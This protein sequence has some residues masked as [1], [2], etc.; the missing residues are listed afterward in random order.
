METFARVADIMTSNPH[1]V[2]LGENMANAEKLMNQWRVHH[3]PVLHEGHLRGIV[4]ERD[5]ALIRSLELDPR[6]VGVAEAL[7]PEPYTVSA[8]AP[9]GRVVRAMAAHRYECAVVVEG[10]E[11]RGIVTATDAMR[12]LA[13][14]IERHQPDHNALRPGQVRELILLEHQHLRQLL[15]RTVSAARTVIEGG[16]SEADVDAMRA[17]ARSA[18]TALVSHT[19]LED[20]ILAPVLE[21]IDAWGHVRAKSLRQEHVAQ[22]LSLQRALQ[23]VSEEAPASSAMLA[24]SVEDVLLDIFRDMEREEAEV[25]TS[26]L[27]SDDITRPSADAG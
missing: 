14:L 13:D 15:R 27:L 7:V 17:M 1:W 4:C 9:L 10:G 24:A 20:R 12:A 23:A 2:A 26:D 25:L 19:E 3:L 8:Q 5:V 22:R 18:L 21:T 16:T 11:V 6:E